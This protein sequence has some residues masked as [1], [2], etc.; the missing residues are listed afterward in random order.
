MKKILVLLFSSLLIASCMQKKMEVR[1][2]GVALHDGTVVHYLEAGQGPVLI[3]VHGLGS[4]SSAWR[5]SMVH[6]ARSYRVLA[7]DLPGY[8]KSDKPEADYSVQY[9]A[10]VVNEFIDSQGTDKVTLAGNSLGGWIAALVALQKPNKVKGLILVSSAGL[11]RQDQL[12]ANP[13]PVTK[14]EERQLLLA[15]YANQ[16]L[17]TEKLVNEQWEYSK[18][19]RPAVL[20]SI[21]AFQMKPPFL[22]DRLKDIKTPTLIIWGRQDKLIPV[23]TAER[24][25]KGIAGS[26]MVV[27]ENAG[28]LPQIEQP[29]AFSRALKKFVKSW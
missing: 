11:R 5:D 25:A 22:D 14:E 12:P 21:A 27:I 1:S 28:H 6:L 9:L 20:A 23:Q 10:G 13:A 24:F 29:K 2:K 16:S 3:L 17:V 18:Q 8:G 4:S 7:L 15:V 26:E 19:V